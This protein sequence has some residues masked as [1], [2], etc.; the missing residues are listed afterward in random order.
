MTRRD[1]DA[2]AD[3]QRRRQLQEAYEKDR[4]RLQREKLKNQMSAR[5]ETVPPNK[6]LPA[7]AWTRKAEQSESSNK[8]SEEE[9]EKMIERAQK[10][11]R[12]NATL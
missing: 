2:N 7:G 12:K 11:W 5:L 9:L 10:T 6:D 8:P 3:Y 4:R 1:R